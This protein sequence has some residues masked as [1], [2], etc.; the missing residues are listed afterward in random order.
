VE[1]FLSPKRL[2]KMNRMSRINGIGK[3]ERDLV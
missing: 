1:L 3:M 2:D